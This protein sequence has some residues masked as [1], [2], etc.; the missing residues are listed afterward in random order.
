MMSVSMSLHVDVDVGVD[1]SYYSFGSNLPATL[2]VVVYH[3][4]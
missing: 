2:W 3:C 1:D 4:A